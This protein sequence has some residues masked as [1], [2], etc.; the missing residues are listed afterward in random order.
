MKVNILMEKK[1]E[2]EK[3]F[4]ANEKLLFECEYCN[5]KKWNGSIKEYND[6]FQLIF[7]GKLLNGR[8]N[9]KGKEYYDSGKVI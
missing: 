1:I 2:I 6:K 7:E 4:N 5:G 3:N 9:G 8:K